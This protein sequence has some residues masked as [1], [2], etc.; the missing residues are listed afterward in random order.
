MIDSPAPIPHATTGSLAEGSWARTGPVELDA[1]DLIR[2]P[3]LASS[4]GFQRMNER[5]RASEAIF[6]SHRDDSPVSLDAQLTAHLDQWV[7]EGQVEG[8]LIGSEDGFV[9]A[10]SSRLEG[11]D[12]LAVV[13][14]VFEFVARRIQA[15]NLIEA[16]EEFAAR[17]SDGAQIIMRYFPGMGTR[18]FLVAYARQPA[19]YR[20][21]M[22]R[23]LKRCGEI[24]A[25]RTGTPIPSQRRS[26]SRATP[27]SPSHESA[28][29]RPSASAEDAVP[30]HPAPSSCPVS[31]EPVPDPSPAAALPPDSLPPSPSHPDSG[32]APFPAAYADGIVTRSEIQS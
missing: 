22:A 32:D 14:T 17:G 7:D 31:T 19:T 5:L 2:V 6:A 1:V 4:G 27:P 10:R 21:T 11:A 30:F 15:E 28:A 13:G 25:A 9:V 16:I 12:L 29:S 3:E 8:L 24:L 26:R 18:F 20:R 23:A